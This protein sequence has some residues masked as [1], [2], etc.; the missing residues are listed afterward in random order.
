MKHGKY[1]EKPLAHL[2]KRI[3]ETRTIQIEDFEPYAPSNNAQVMFIGTPVIEEGKVIS[4]IVLQISDI[5]INKIVNQ[6]S[7][8]GKSSELYLIGKWKE[9]QTSL[10]NNR[11][12]KK[13]KIGD[14][15]SDDIIKKCFAGDDGFETKIGST[16]D[17]EY[18]CYA[19]LNLRGLNW[20]VFSTIKESEVMILVYNYG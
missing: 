13:G 4:V 20:S 19:P 11:I 3:V 10:R 6:R 7:G 18:I 17:K 14:V 1:R 12:V 2:W 15:K 5:P 8:M 9:N 16:G